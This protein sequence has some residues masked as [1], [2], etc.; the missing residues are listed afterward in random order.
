M[1]CAS[2]QPTPC[3]YFPANLQKALCAHLP[4]RPPAQDQQRPRPTDLCIK[5]T[6]I[7]LSM[8]SVVCFHGGIH[9]TR[10]SP[11]SSDFQDI[12]RAE[13]LPPVK[14]RR[15]NLNSSTILANV[16]KPVQPPILA[17]LCTLQS[18]LP[19]F[20]QLISFLIPSTE[21]ASP[22]GT[23]KLLKLHMYKLQLVLDPI[24]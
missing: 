22:S 15:I 10:G 18:L 6:G 23:R 12:V 13:S 19:S 7:G 8:V 14:L 16:F 4:K 17:L 24:Q 5:N 11:A 9:S 1:F 21:P 2:N 20:S 3:V